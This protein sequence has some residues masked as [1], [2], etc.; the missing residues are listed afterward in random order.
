MVFAVIL[1]GAWRPLKLL[2]EVYCYRKHSH[3][4]NTQHIL[5]GYRHRGEEELIRVGDEQMI[6]T[7][8]YFGLTQSRPA[9]R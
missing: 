4:Y 8:T 5:Q 2:I 3:Q 1:L 7:Y 6:Y 9:H